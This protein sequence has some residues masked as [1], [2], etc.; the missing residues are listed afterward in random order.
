M[1][2]ET[3]YEL[4][5]YAVRNFLIIVAALLVFVAFGFAKLA[6]Q[7]RAERRRK[8]AGFLQPD[9]KQRT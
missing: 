1:D 4:I 9:P 2:T 3:L 7:E 8:N 5:P 6:L